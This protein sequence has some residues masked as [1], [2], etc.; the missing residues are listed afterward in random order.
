MEK[1]L[2]ANELRYIEREICNG[3][4]RFPCTA[5]LLFSPQA[6]ESEWGWL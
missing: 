2:S 5:F 4:A 1:S 3:I 6:Y